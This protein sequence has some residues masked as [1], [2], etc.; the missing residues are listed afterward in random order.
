MHAVRTVAALCLCKELWPPLLNIVT[1]RL[2]SAPIQG[3]DT[4]FAP[5]APKSQRSLGPSNGLH[6]ERRELRDSRAG[7]IKQLEHRRIAQPRR[8]RGI[9]G[10]EQ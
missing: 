6:V 5:L 9:G 2:E 4:L 3:Y 1:G 10:L 8:R 7:G